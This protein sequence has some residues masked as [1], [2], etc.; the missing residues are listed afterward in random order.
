MKR[1]FLRYV[2]IRILQTIPVLVG[3]SMV[4]FVIIHFA[5]G[6][7]VVN[8]LGIQATEENIQELR[9]AYG[10]DQPLYIQ[11]LEWLSGILRG[12]FGRSLTQGGRPVADL[13]RSRLPATLFLAVSSLFVSVVIALPAGVL[14]AV[15]KNTLTDYGVSVGA[16]S[17]VSIP[18]FWL[19]LILIL[20]LARI[21]GVLPAGNY[22][23]PA[24]RPIAALE[25]VVL[26]AITVGTAYAALLTRQTRS[27]VLDNL[28]TDNVRMAKSKGLAPRRIL[29]HHVLKQSLLPVITVAGL[30][31]G[32]M[33]SATVVVEQ[34][35][36]WPG[37]G[38]LI[39]LAVRQQDYP[40]VQGTVLVIAFIF[41]MVNLAVDLAY[42][43]LDPR[44]SAA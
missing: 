20:L 32:Y 13:I 40:T 23:S 22:V 18:N 17:G 3:I 29:T 28:D 2:T 11:Y 44:V 16:L 12:D 38:R 19:G 42:S 43:Y 41:V 26:P 15:K 21:L 35:F 1:G 27:A 25:H 7:P 31:F 30:Q 8:R 24:E 10:L 36:A 9:R 5:P 37:L 33:L 14:S 4:V 34:V 6:D 39:W